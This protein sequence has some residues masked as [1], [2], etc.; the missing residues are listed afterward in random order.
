[1]ALLGLWLAGCAGIGGGGGASTAAA[2]APIPKPGAVLLAPA[3]FNQTLPEKLAA[4]IPALQAAIRSQLESDGVRVEAPSFEEFH[5]VWLAAARDVGSLYD[6]KGDF[7]PGRFDQAVRNLADAYRAR[8]VE[9]DVLLLPYLRYRP[10][11]I[12][13]Q[14]VQWDGVTHH[15][16]LQ[17]DIRNSVHIESRRRF[18]VACTS[19]RVFGFDR[20]GNRLFESYGGLE[21]MSRM[22]MKDG[23]VH[24]EE[25][26]DLFADQSAIRE[27]V[28]VALKPVLQD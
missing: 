1:V 3:S 28:G 11:T 22:V 15:L 17:S 10:G 14:S 21:V 27:G 18:Q 7:D 24:W 12:M 25:R 13:G 4:G 19:L 9:F 6:G 16:P 2:V 20:N 26:T 8:G 5:D 23:L